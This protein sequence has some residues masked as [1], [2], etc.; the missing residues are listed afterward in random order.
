[1][2][3]VQNPTLSAMRK[4]GKPDHFF[5]QGVCLRAQMHGAAT[6]VGATGELDASNIH[7]LTNYVRRYL[8]GDRPLVLDLS[9]LDFLAAQGIRCLFEIAD[10]CDRNGIEWALVPGR[11]VLRF[12]RICDKDAWL[13]AV[14]SIDE[15]VQCFSAPWGRKDYCSSSRSR[16]NVRA[17]RRDTCI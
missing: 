1:M 16:A 13:P 5:G 6:V 4:S 10:E 12:L 14:S 9:Q 2:T 11:P 17:S 8:S 7:H 3:A 15:A